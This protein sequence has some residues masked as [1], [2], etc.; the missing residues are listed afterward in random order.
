MPQFVLPTSA[1]VMG[2]VSSFL[3][4]LIII[5]T[6]Q[7]H[8][9]FSHD[10]SAGVQKIHTQP[11]PRVGGIA[12]LFGLTLSLFFASNLTIYPLLSAMILSALPVFLLGTLE[13]ITKSI[14]PTMRLWAAM[15]SGVLA[16]W[17]TG[18]ALTSVDV[19]GVDYLLSF[20]PVAVVFTA[21]CIAGMA[22][23]INVIDGLNGLASGAMLI[24][25][26][27][28]SAIAYSAGDFIYVYIC[29]LIAA[30]AFGFIL[31]NFPF[32]KIFLGDGGAYLLG[33]L[34]GGLA[35]ML[36]MRNESIS[37]WA[38]LLVFSYPILEVLFSIFRR[39]RRAHSPYHPDR[40]HLHSLIQARLFKNLTRNWLRPLQNSFASLIPWCFMLL[41]NLL[42]LQFKGS[43]PALMLCFIFMAITY[44]FIYTY[45]VRFGHILRKP[46]R[47]LAKTN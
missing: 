2:G 46:N 40:L 12:I 28:L 38:P 4:C 37:V 7:W 34:G 1:L 3:I 13:D 41:G 17:L 26:L 6:Q 19:W 45:L 18:F 5:V 20:T 31:F 10:H 27:F 32:G 36:P 8:G 47:D 16:W 15:I 29:L 24:A 23:A 33:F 14:S 25:L 42:A 9:K 35:V 11:T 43:T 39:R 22:N 44:S 21:F 30:V